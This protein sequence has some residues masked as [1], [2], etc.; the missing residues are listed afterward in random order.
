MTPQEIREAAALQLLQIIEEV[1]PSTATL[2]D[3]YLVVS[4]RAVMPLD[5]VS[6]SLDRTN[7]L[8]ISD[9]HGVIFGTLCL[10]SGKGPYSIETMTRWQYS[11]Y[12]ADCIRGAVGS[13]THQFTRD[14]A[15]IDA[16]EL[17][18]YVADYKAGSALWGG[19]HHGASSVPYAG[20][21]RD[22]VARPKVILATEYHRR[23][24]ML[25]AL[26]ASPQEQYLKLY[27]TIELL[28][29]YVTFRK[30][31]KSGNNLAGFGKVM[32][33]YQRSE[34]DKLKAIFKEYC[35]N[36]RAVASKM[37]ALAPYLDR[38]EDMFQAHSKEGNPLGTD[39]QWA[40]FCDLVRSGAIDFEDFK[41]VKLCQKIDSY[42][43]FI[44]KI[45]AYHVY[46]IRS[47]IA[48]SRIGEYV[49]SESDNDFITTYAIPL[50]EEIT[51]QIFSGEGMSELVR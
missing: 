35:E 9:E 24:F 22:I 30:L 45:A 12:L 48:H 17:E 26:A 37:P 1:D 21:K 2:E 13:E 15:V 32:S 18:R 46:R 36:P 23:S 38:A 33:T 3:G 31:V 7:D 40:R 29:D 19:F 25:T 4:R 14:Y 44:T 42:D 20:W 49:L 43:E 6:W 16:S 11:A 50:I 39:D 28:F 41:R 34:L 51:I 47:S 27:H 8:E 10:V 5:G